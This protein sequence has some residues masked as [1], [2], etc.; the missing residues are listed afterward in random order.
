MTFSPIVE[1]ELRVASRRRATFWT[2][3]VFAVVAVAIACVTLI[4][5]GAFQSK[6]GAGGRVFAALTV[7]GFAFC[8]VAGVF[9]TSDCLSEEKREGT[10]GL[11]FL[12]DLKGYDVVLGK[13]SVRSLTAFYGVFAMFPVLAITLVLGGVTPGE[14]WRMT[15]VF[16]NT[17][18]LSLTAGLFVSS[19]SRQE[20][21]A[22]VGTFLLLLLVI[23][24]LPAV[25]ALA[26]KTGGGP[27]GLA[28]FSPFTTCRLAF[29]A[30]Y[31]LD[32]AEFWQSVLS[33]QLLSWLMLVLATLLL[34]RLWQEGRGL[35][36][37][38]AQPA[39]IDEIEFARRAERRAPW[40]DRNPVF[41]LTSRNR[42]A[43]WQL[44]LGL[45]L[46][47]LILLLVDLGFASA[48]T[49]SSS[50]AAWGLP[51]VV[52]VA[53]ALQACRFFVEARRAG[54]MELLLCTPL[55]VKELLR[56]Q[57]L[58]LRRLY[59]M[60]VILVLVI[61]AVS[62]AMQLVNGNPRSL[63][64]T[65]AL[66]GGMLT[67]L[68]DVVAIGWMGMLIGLTTRKPH[69]AAGYTLLFMV[70]LPSVVL[71]FRLL[72]DIPVIFWARDRLQRELRSLVSQRYVAAVTPFY[73]RA[74]RRPVRAPPPLAR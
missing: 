27:A 34:P 17:L 46:L 74:D 3:M 69:L 36:L 29:D 44:W 45:A 15:I 70:V 65:S 24:V 68:A 4:V 49:R 62:S 22:M 6:S 21:R 60:P 52:R 13:L 72:I 30:P 9:L 59:L 50:T 28:L 48:G 31:R 20:Q 58:T 63:L 39:V 18:F 14:F 38:R 55:S 57:W 16:V 12:T 56:G 53:V 40:L 42:H 19:I 8:A 7:M 25:D 41:W 35:N 71:S 2:R 51:L 10:L 32:H 66:G 47:G 33:T 54:T 1:R 5:V 64:Q 43:A 23:G 67:F 37:R 26:N 11:L 61:Q 73:E